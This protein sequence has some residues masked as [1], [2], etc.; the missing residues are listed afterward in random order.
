MIC[1]QA[2]PCSVLKELRA[3][4]LRKMSFALKICDFG[5]AKEFDRTTVDSATGTVRWMA[6]EVHMYKL[7]CTFHTHRMVVRHYALV[8]ITY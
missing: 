2:T 8:I 4:T 3:L 5:T 6:P 7:T 1:N